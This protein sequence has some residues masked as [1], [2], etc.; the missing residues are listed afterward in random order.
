LAKEQAEARFKRKESQARDATAAMAEY[1]AAQVATRKKT[2]RLRALR[3]AKEAE[4]A[5]AT[6]ATV[7]RAAPAPASAPRKKKKT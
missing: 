2:E 7:T 1:E 3:L 4:E 6:K 5:K